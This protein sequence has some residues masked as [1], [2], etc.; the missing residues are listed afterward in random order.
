MIRTGN[1][2]ETTGKQMR[3]GQAIKRPTEINRS[4]H[5]SQTVGV[6]HVDPVYSCYEGAWC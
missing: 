1:M 6:A 5:C 3:P 2:V 4:S